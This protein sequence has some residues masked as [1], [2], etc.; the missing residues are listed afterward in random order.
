[1]QKETNAQIPSSYK[2]INPKVFK[3]EKISYDH[4]L[5][6]RNMQTK[7]CVLQMLCNVL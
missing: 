6:I 2:N 4:L 7:V 1:M 3:S 5:F